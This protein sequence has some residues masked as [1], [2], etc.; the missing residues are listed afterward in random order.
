MQAVA[1]AKALWQPLHTGR[2]K[3]KGVAMKKR[4]LAIVGLGLGA[5]VLAYL[6][7]SWQMTLKS[8]GLTPRGQLIAQRVLTPL[9]FTGL[10]AMAV[11]AENL[12][13]GIPAS[14]SKNKFIAVSKWV[15]ILMLSGM[16]ILCTQGTPFWSFA[17]PAT[18]DR[19]R[20]LYGWPIPWKGED[21]TAY[22]PLL[23]PVNLALWTSYT[24]FLFG[25]RALR[26]YVGI[27]VVIGL[28]V[29]LLLIP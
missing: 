3:R 19:P 8:L 23:L 6:M 13:Q 18:W 20:F 16:L 2:G 12:R 4:I 1:V 29:G 15:A 28:L 5:C 25:R 21:R 9:F 26:E 14:F 22:L 27:L 7:L 24:M 17:A 11:S 10:A